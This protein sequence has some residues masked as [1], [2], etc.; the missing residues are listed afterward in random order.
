MYV[1]FLWLIVDSKC[2]MILS[3]SNLRKL[4]GDQMSEVSLT[5]WRDKWPEDDCLTTSV[6]DATFRRVSLPKV[7]NRNEFTLSVEKTD[8]NHPLSSHTTFTVPWPLLCVDS[9]DMSQS[10][11]TVR[12]PRDLLQNTV[13]RSS[14][15]GGDAAT[16]EWGE[17]P[18]Q[19]PVCH[20]HPWPVV[21]SS[22]WRRSTSCQWW[23]PCSHCAC[24]DN[25]CH[26][27][28]IMITHC[29][30]SSLRVKF[31]QLSWF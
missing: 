3:F 19:G 7:C 14:A 15:R 1:T 16:T 28:P 21:T 18:G 9:Y 12:D 23:A 10:Q 5:M 6:L 30:H 25:A 27:N 17:I 29:L 11:S 2:L 31:N 20:V 13:T 8:E 26:L 24:L 4:V 22:H